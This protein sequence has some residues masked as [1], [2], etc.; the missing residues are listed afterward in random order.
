MTTKKKALR[1]NKILNSEDINISITDEHNEPD[2]TSMG[3]TGKSYG[4]I[5]TINF[6]HLTISSMN[7]TKSNIK[8]KYGNIYKDNFSTYTNINKNRNNKT[9][10]INIEV[11]VI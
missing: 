7:Q 8:N 4:I 2:I 3:E 6:P 5:S 1:K 11:S 10:E 9:D